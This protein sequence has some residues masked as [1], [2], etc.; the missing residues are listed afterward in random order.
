MPS[1]FRF[2]TARGPFF[3]LYNQR[4]GKWEIHHDNDCLDSYPTP[5]TAAEDLAGG[6]C[7]WPAS[8]DP[9]SLGISEDLSDWEPL[10]AR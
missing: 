9:S 5:Q 8:G 2:N 4:T 1:G 6:Y 10:T 3:I 7:T